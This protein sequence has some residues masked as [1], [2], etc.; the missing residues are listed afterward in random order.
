VGMEN[1]LINKKNIS[2]LEM[3]SV[4]SGKFQLPE[5]QADAF[6]RALAALNSE[7]VPYV[8]EG[9][10]AIYFYCGIWR[11]TKDLDIFVE[12]TNVQPALAA[13]D[14]AGFQTHIEEPIWLSKAV[15]NGCCVDIIHGSGNR[16]AKIDNAWI[17]RGRPAVILG[18][19]C[20]IAS[21]EDTISFKAYIQERHR[22]DGADVV[23]IIV[24]EKGKL[25]WD[26]LLM[27]MGEHWPVLLTH[28]INFFFVYPSH[29]DY[30]PRWVFDNLMDRLRSAMDNPAE[31]FPVC[32]G[33]LI[34]TFSYVADLERGYQDAR[35]LFQPD[36]QPEEPNDNNGSD[37]DEREAA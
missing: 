37:S 4:T 35:K 11:T 22:Y 32:Q 6:R 34:S 17:E 16:V 3:S 28:L 25:D 29:R 14:R 20:L 24:G 5:A 31:V 7:Q 12:E 1:N 10:F 19:K 30:V 26:H 21:P 8:V 13:L 18:Q 33:T 23:H 15:Y 36:A 2:M 27:R 9:A